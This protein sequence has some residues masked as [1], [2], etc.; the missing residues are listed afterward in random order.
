MELNGKVALVT[1]GAKRVGL[2]IARHLGDRG[3]RIVIHYNT[4]S[5]QAEKAI[6]DLKTKGISARIVQGD[7]A[8]NDDIQRFVRQAHDCFGRLD[9]LVN[10][11]AVFPRTP[12]TNIRPED[13]DAVM[14]VNARG[15]FLC[16]QA[17]APFMRENGGVIVNIV[18]VR[19]ERPRKD[20][21]PYVASKA[22][23]LS[24]TYGLARVL[25]PNIR[26]NA[27]GPGP[28]LFPEDYTEEEKQRS[29]RDTLLKRQGNPADIA[30]AIVFLCENEYIT[31]AYLPVD[32]GL[33]LS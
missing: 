17:A 30:S 22:A 23:L 21:L 20:Y 9:I 25:A 14:D 33:S 1:G 19:T 29:I 2:E 28:V 13:W 8:D 31:G 12:F 15:A 18:D 3:A 6:E 11:A 32:G 10:N 24:V 5:E 4:S 27:V 7:L 16:A 26:V